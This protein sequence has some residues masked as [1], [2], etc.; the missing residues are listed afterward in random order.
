MTLWDSGEFLAAIATLGTPHPPGTPLFVHAARAWHVLLHGVP[1][2]LAANLFSAVASALAGA[3]G[4]WLVARW[5]RHPGAGVAAAI[6]GGTMATVWQAATETEVYAFATLAVVAGVGIADRAIRADGAR[7]RALLAFLF[8]LAVPLHLSVLVVGP[9]LVV[10]AT[11][12]ARGGW[13]WRP[14]LALAGAWSVA[15]GLGTVRALPVAAGVVVTLASARRA[16]GGVGRA[17]RALALVLLGASAVLVMP[18]RARHDPGLN[19]GNP[20]TP[21]ALA[22]VVA[23][24]QYD[25][26]PPWPRRAPPWLQVGNVLQWADWQ[27]A[28][29]ASEVLGPSPVRTPLTILVAAL[30]VVGAAWHRRRDARSF[31]ALV[32]LMAC[33]TLG[34]VAVLNL[35]AGPTFGWGV[36]PD[37]ALREARERDY[38]FA[39]AFLLWGWWSGCGVAALRA[40]LGRRVAWGLVLLP[41]VGNWRAVDRSRGPEATLARTVGRGMLDGLPTGAVLLLAGDNDAFPAWYAQHAEGRRPDVVAVAVPL[42]G[43]RWYRAELA[44]RH[45]LLPR[46]LVDRWGGV[47]ATLEAVGA[48]AAAAGR[49]LASAVSVAAADRVAAGGTD[50]WALHGLWYLRRPGAGRTVLAPPALRRAAAMV[51]RERALATPAREPGA[52]W[53][54]GI[55]RCPAAAL[56]RESATVPS[57]DPLLE[58]RCNF[59]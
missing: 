16:D 33:A 51:R 52:R 6:M 35:R 5:T 7:W 9:A 4:A 1:L 11:T 3:L 32:M 30:G 57:G 40:Q 15:V 46:A 19:E 14:A 43:A 12:D 31:R 58:A 10:L 34:V 28:S 2:A 42:L 37:G 13:T 56:A 44:R 59:R 55:L 24:R 49:P 53:V 45:A 29:A 17:L 36:L 50:A 27:V 38:F 26:P 18:V 47:A 21:A 54:Q 48:T 8:G 25:V 23:R 39:V 41:V 22:D 20:A